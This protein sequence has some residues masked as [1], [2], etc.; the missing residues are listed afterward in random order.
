V[1][2]RRLWGR[3]GTAALALLAAG[4][5]GAAVADSIRKSSH[6]R[7]TVTHALKPQRDAGLR[8]PGRRAIAARLERE[9]ARGVLYFVDPACRLRALL[10][11]ALESAPAPRDGGCRALISPSTAPPGWSLWPRDTPLAAYCRRGRV[12]V[13]GSVGESLPMIGG[14]APAWR[15]D[16]S[17][18][19]VRRGAIVQ[20]PRTGRARVVRSRDQLALALEG[21]SA[22]RRTKGWRATNV[23]W[24]GPT[25]FAIVAERAGRAV[26]AV[27]AGR[28]IVALARVPRGVSELSASP[29]GTYLVLRVDGRLH[30]YRVARSG[31]GPVRSFGAPVAIAWSPD[32][33]WV[34]VARA[35]RIVLTRA[36][37]RIALP[38][39]AIDLAWTRAL[40]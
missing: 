4:V 40:P 1:T 31:L 6:R 7:R 25:R 39:P 34:A 11:P 28:R 3:A 20:F 32:E 14:C 27:F 38:L 13:S 15:P 24:L 23:A 12:I 5:I 29:R 37:E 18:T 30:L 17:M 16:G 2:R 9:G 21:V 33:R 35:D 36:R 8:L 19:Y 10:L 26:L 22:L